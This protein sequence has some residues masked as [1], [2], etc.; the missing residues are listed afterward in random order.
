MLRVVS[1]LKPRLSFLFLSAIA[2]AL[3]LFSCRATPQPDSQA[4][5]RAQES[6]HAYLGYD[7]N[8]FPGTDALPVLRKTFAFSSYWLSPPPGEKTNTWL[9][10]RVALRSEGF[11]FLLLYRG[12]ESSETKTNAAAVEKGSA[13]A[14]DAASVA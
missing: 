1:N 9:G 8:I 12:R 11:G 13:D 14:R 5:S 6:P 7:R 4:V 10:R 2:A 3:I